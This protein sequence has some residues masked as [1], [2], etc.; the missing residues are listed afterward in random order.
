[1]QVGVSTASLFM[2][3]YNEDALPL[4][5][6]LGVKTAEVFLT[7]FSEYGKAFGELLAS[8]KG[9]LQINSVHDLN[10]EF[11]P[12]LFSAHPRVRADAYGWLDQV[13]DSAN[14]LGAPYYTFHGTSRVKRAS[15]SGEN[16]DFPSMI[17]GF[18]E[19]TTHCKARGVTLCLENVEWSTY[20]RVGVFSR[21]AEAVPALRGVLDIKQ[22]RISEYPYHLY[23]EEMGEKL[24]YAH[25]SDITAEGKMCLP[26][27]GIFDFETMIKRLQD[28]GF[29]GALIIEVYENDYEQ[30]EE[31]KISCDYLN[32]LL[33]KLG[34][35]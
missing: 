18:E 24:A 21:L 3:K 16:D 14:A 13:L 29:D 1:M 5:N 19:L 4:L 32:E 9:S 22:A 12:Q 23:L 26:G 7:S 31:L 35:K 30:E 28:V 6:E 17:K 10:T 20:N 33:Y 27:K 25:L 15:R 34:T 8:R 11:E 2:R